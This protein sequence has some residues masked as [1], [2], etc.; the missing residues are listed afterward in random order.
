MQRDHTPSRCVTLEENYLE[1]LHFYQINAL[2]N[3]EF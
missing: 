2:A 3:N 1:N